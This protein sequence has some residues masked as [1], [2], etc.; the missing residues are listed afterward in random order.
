M[1]ARVLVH[2]DPKLLVKLDCD[3]LSVGIGAVLSHVFPDR[4]EKPISFASRTLTKAEKNYAQIEREALS[5][6]W[7]IKKFHLYLYLQ[8]FTLVTDQKPLIVLFK[9]YKAI[10]V[11][12]LGRIQ[13]WALFLMDYGY[14]IQ[15]QSTVKHANAGIEIT[16]GS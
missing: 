15:F 4:T 6:V 13:R 9:P 10:P 12:A 11:L 14:N 7:G 16:V 3:A 2:Y 5:I 8:K 1:S